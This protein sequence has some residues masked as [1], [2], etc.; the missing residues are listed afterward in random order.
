MEPVNLQS[1]DIVVVLFTIKTPEGYLFETE[2]WYGNNMTE[3][4][5]LNHL[6]YKYHKQ[7]VV[8]INNIY[9]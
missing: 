1:E 9:R 8:V 2:H 3:E 7:G 5:L 4:M 6:I